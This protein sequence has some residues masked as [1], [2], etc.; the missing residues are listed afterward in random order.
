MIRRLLLTSFV[1][2]G[3]F[4]CYFTSKNQ[5]TPTRPNYLSE[6]QAERLIQSRMAKHGVKFVSNMK[7]VR[8]GLSFVADGYDRD[9]RVGFEYRSHEDGDFE[10][11]KGGSPDGLTEAEIQ[12]LRARQD[13]YH[14]YFLI[15]PEGDQQSV[16]DAVDDFIKKLYAWEVLKKKTVQEVDSLF[17]T[18]NKG[19]DVLPW[20]T[21]GD[22]KEKRKAMEEREK[23]PKDGGDDEALPDK[24]S[25]PGKA[26]GR[27]DDWQG[28]VDSEDSTAKP[29]Q[30]PEKMKKKTKRAEPSEDDF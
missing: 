20:E 21:T 9:L 12:V 27:D 8:E 14:E 15:V 1:A 7:L 29:K 24:A 23:S 10:D 17:P 18:N 30:K 3:L 25:P 16:E 4:G 2:S 11:E 28:D 19:G 5:R 6:A 26:E 22:V 13:V